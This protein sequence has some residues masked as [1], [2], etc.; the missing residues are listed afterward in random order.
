MLKKTYDF[1]DLEKLI[2]SLM[3][4]AIHIEP[5][6]RYNEYLYPFLRAS[7]PFFFLCSSYFFFEKCQKTQYSI[8]TLVDF[9]KRNFMLYI[10]WSIVLLPV[11]IFTNRDAHGIQLFYR[12]LRCFIMT[13]TFGGSWYLIAL[14]IGMT[15]VYFSAKNK[16]SFYGI[17]TISI[18]FAILG[19]LA[20]NYYVY[21]EGTIIEEIL[22]WYSGIFNMPIYLSFPISMFWLCMGKIMCEQKTRIFNF[23]IDVLAIGTIISLI[24]L[25]GEKYVLVDY[26]VNAND[27]YIMNYFVVSFLFMLSLRIETRISNAVAMRTISTVIFCAHHSINRI[28]SYLMTMISLNIRGIG[29]SIFRYI[30][31]IVF[32]IFIERV[33]YILAPKLKIIKWMR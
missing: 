3:V 14:I 30:M 5:L 31:T 24:L 16:Y 29:N 25:V 23:N 33:L 32:C 4:A 9:L 21:I 27:C 22:T 7:V 1:I 13:G 11:V 17:L 18:I 28:L 10:I 20:T 12:L 26:E 19:C 6:A 8:K 15:I 2:M